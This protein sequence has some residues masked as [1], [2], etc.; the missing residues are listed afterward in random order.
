MHPHYGGRTIEGRPRYCPTR[1]QGPAPNNTQPLH[2]SILQTPDL[3]GTGSLSHHVLRSLRKGRLSSLHLGT[4]RSDIVLQYVLLRRHN[5]RLDIA[6]GLWL[7]SGARRR[8]GGARGLRIRLNRYNPQYHVRHRPWYPSSQIFV[9]LVCRWK[10]QQ[11]VSQGGSR[12]CG[13]YF[14]GVC[15]LKSHGGAL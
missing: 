11:G 9:L 1:V 2:N 5:A 6:D 12:R 14:C 13:R 15:T 10:G 3:D 8:C 4:A 7:H